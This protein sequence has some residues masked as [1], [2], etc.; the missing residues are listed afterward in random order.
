M[1]EKVKTAKSNIR[2]VVLPY[3]GAAAMLALVAA[4]TLSRL[5]VPG[6]DFLQGVLMGFS[7][8]GN[9]AAIWQFRNKNKGEYDA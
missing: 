3:I 7:I 6:T 9:I 5:D 8:V 1:L 2:A 4:I